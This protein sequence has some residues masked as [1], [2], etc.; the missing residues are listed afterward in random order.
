MLTGDDQGLRH[1][2]RMQSCRIA[3]SDAKDE[4]EGD[5]RRRQDSDPKDLIEM[6]LGIWKEND[7]EVPD[8]EAYREAFLEEWKAMN[9]AGEVFVIIPLT[10]RGEYEYGCG[11]AAGKYTRNGY[12]VLLRIH[13]DNPEAVQFLA[14]MMEE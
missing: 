6:C 2:L 3:H 11:V 4:Y 12:V 7:A 8:P 13:K 10:D 9:P 1:K 14:D 5:L